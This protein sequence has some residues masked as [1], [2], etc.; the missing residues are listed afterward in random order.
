[1]SHRIG[2]TRNWNTNWDMVIEARFSRETKS[3]ILVFLLGILTCIISCRVMERSIQTTVNE[4]NMELFEETLPKACATVNEDAARIARVLYGVKD[5]ELSEKAKTA[6]I[7]IILNRV[8]DTDREFRNLNTIE[9]VCEQPEQWQG[10]KADG[11]YLQE[12][13]DLALTVLNNDRGGRVIPDNCYFLLA[14]HGEVVVRTEFN[15]GNE[16]RV[17]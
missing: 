5:Y 14:S 15:G 1:M 11:E 13:Y 3:H 6:V 2:P 12:D 9:A 7:E 8:A 17:K 16:W 4:T 10:Y